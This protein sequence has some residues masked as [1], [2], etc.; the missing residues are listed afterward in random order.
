[1]A[2][3][4]EAIRAVAAADEYA[5]LRNEVKHEDDLIGQRVSWFMASQAFLLVSLAIA[6]KGEVAVRYGLAH[7]DGSLK[8]CRYVLDLDEPAHHSDEGRAVRHAGRCPEGA[9]GQRLNQM[10]QLQA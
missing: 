2:E 10:A 3:R 6:H 4:N 7:Q 1:M 8:E 5:T 9:A